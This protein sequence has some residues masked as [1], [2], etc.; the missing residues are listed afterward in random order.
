MQKEVRRDI[1]RKVA[2]AQ[3]AEVQESTEHSAELVVIVPTLYEA[4]NLPELTRR[5]FAA[6]SKAFIATE[7]LIV[8]DNSQ[9]GTEEI[10]R[11]LATSIR[12]V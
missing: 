12:F 2:C 8:D 1:E 9:D 11:Q 6:V 10:V 3:R 7:L 4:D 5:I